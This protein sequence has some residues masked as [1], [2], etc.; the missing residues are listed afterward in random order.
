M[1]IISSNKLKEIFNYHSEGFLTWAVKYSRKV[2]IGDIAGCKKPGPMYL[3][4]KIDGRNYLLHR[5][6][7]AYHTGEWP[8][9][10]DHINGNPLDNRF[11]NLRPLSLSLNNINSNKTWSTTGYRGVSICKKTGKF[12]ARIGKKRKTIWLGLYSTAKEASAV[13]EAK[14]EELYP[15]VYI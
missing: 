8:F 12:Q 10:I 3:Y 9:P 6:I 14:R 2:N 5:V 1:N 7:Y 11:E 4:V 13:Y 15:G